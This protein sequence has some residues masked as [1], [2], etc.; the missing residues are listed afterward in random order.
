MAVYQYRNCQYEPAAYWNGERWTAA[1][2]ISQ[3]DGARRKQKRFTGEV[4]FQNRVEALAESMA[5]AMR[6][7]D[8]LMS[9]AEEL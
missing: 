4:S 8:G 6:I 5:L 3:G 2:M 7:I 9:G 1:V